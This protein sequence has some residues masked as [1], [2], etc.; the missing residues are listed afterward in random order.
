MNA[1][2]LVC[3]DGPRVE[4]CD[5]ELPEPGPGHIVIRTLASGISP[6]T[7]LALMQQKI[8]WGPFPLC[9]GYQAVGVVEDVGAQATGY[10]AGQRVYYRDNAAMHL[11]GGPAVSCVSGTHASRA[12]VDPQRTHGLAV[13][14]DGVDVAAASLYA[15]PA[16]GLNGVDM[17]NPRMGQ[18]VVVHGVGLVGLGV[19]AA[20][21]HRGCRVIAIDLDSHRLDV[22]RALGA[23]ELVNGREV[24]ARQ[25]LRELAPNMADVV[26][27][28]TGSP[29]CLDPAIAMCRTHGTFVW[30]GNY[31]EQP[32]SLK[33]LGAHN[34]R[35][36]MYFP[37]DDG[38]APC[39]AAVLKNMARGVL[40]WHETI[41]HELEPS[42]AAPLLNRMLAGEGGDVLGAVVHWSA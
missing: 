1:T 4:L 30:Q 20:C 28:C 24:D 15:L 32:V 36:T 5:V 35:L 39:R 22:A 6:G 3:H 29:A 25:R 8:T 19:V 23:D 40:P 33:F 31:G 26:F 11:P 12:V 21:A 27:E 13:L 7:E 16:V 9:T 2:A 10:V 42:D 34:R 37:C 18:T 38:L 14:P 41:T 17:A